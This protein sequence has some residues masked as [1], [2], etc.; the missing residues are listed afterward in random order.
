MKKIGIITFHNSY[1]CGSMMQTYALQQ[2]L[3]KKGIKSEIIDYYTPGQTDVYSVFNKN[4]SIKNLIINTL[5]FPFQKRIYNN[6]N[7][8][9][10]F[11]EKNFVKSSRICTYN[12]LEKLDYSIVVSGSDQVWNITI[13]DVDDAYF[14]PW[15]KNARKVAY[16]P[17]FGAK[18]IAH[19]TND[20][21]KYKK[22]LNA[23]D[24]LSIR[25]NNG[26][27]WIKDLIGKDVE[28]LIDPTLL[29]DE[30]DY[31]DILDNNCT[32]KNDYIFFY[33]PTFDISMCDFVKKVSRK[34]NL[35]VIVWSA[36][37]YYKKMVYRYG[38]KLPDYENPSVYLSLIKNAKM[39][40]TTSFHGSVF[41]TIYRKNFFVLKNGGMYGDDDR[42]KTLLESLFLM[43]RLI[44]YKF[45]EKFDYL[46]SVDYVQYETNLKKLQTKAIEYI[47]KNIGAFYENS[48]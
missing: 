30:T 3:R 5:V 43:E 22:F 23:F 20:I 11:S 6:N 38:F 41:S 17:S 27:Q 19:N 28:V 31:N 18:N 42:V 21:E 44:P 46:K 47:D 9:A 8:Y 2:F 16:A 13:P 36:K 24:A 4:N 32:P 14:L 39:I 25:E 12:E 48:K 7:K 29:L 37:S 10:Q 34:Y 40:F 35:P 45:D 26:K 33:C 1:N 15:A